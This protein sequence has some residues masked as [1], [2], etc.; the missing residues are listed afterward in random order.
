MKFLIMFFL[1][2]IPFISRADDGVQ[3]SLSNSRSYI[4]PGSSA[5]CMDLS[6]YK[7]ALLNH[8]KKAMLKTSVLPF[9]V[10]FP[11][12][13]IQWNGKT[14]LSVTIIRVSI[15]SNVLENGK[16]IYDILD[17]ELEDLIGGQLAAN[18]LQS[19]QMNSNDSAR[20]C[21]PKTKTN[22]LTGLSCEPKPASFNPLYAACGFDVGGIHFVNNLP[23]SFV[24]P[25]TIELFG[26]T[27]D[28]AGSFNPV[29]SSMTATVEYTEFL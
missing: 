2:S 20:D 21:D 18:P 28:N 22:V 10:S 11:N 27:T 13:N 4:L 3:M 29:Y 17:Q 12:F 5:N 6:N 26:Y 7:V 14:D 24:A 15:Q 9:R 25:L 16:Y 1:L 19:G 8:T 23:Q